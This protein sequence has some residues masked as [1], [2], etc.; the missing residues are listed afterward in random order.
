[1]TLRVAVAWSS[2]A[3]QDVVEIAL[4]DGATVADA[5]AA[6]DA[7]AR[8]GVDTASA[9]YAIYGQTVRPTTPLADGDRVEIT[10][11]L[12]ADPKVVRR[13]RAKARPLPAVKPRR[14]PGR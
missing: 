10:R 1:M 2:P 14:R 6:C 8:A 3:A 5:V 9:G 4:P 7:L 12:V 11:P 13:D